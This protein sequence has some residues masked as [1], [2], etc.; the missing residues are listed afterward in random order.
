MLNLLVFPAL[1]RV[2]HQMSTV[3]LGVADVILVKP[4]QLVREPKHA[5]LTACGVQDVLTGLETCERPQGSIEGTIQRQRDRAS[6][7]YGLRHYDLR[8]GGT[9]SQRHV[10]FCVAQHSERGGAAQSRRRPRGALPVA[11]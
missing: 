2:G 1:Q 5:L 6:A 9:A 8:G 11:R 3:L 7:W 4:D 10:F